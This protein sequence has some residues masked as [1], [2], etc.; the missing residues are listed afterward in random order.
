MLILSYMSLDQHVGDAGGYIR[1]AVGPCAQ[2]LVGPQQQC[3]LGYISG[4]KHA[5]DIWKE[6]IGDS[7]ASESSSERSDCVT[8]L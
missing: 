8:G 1:A 4:E 2:S 3:I 7:G 5:V 6:W